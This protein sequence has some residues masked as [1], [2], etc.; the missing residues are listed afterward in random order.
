VRVYSGEDD[1]DYMKRAGKNEAN[2][3]YSINS[4]NERIANSGIRHPGVG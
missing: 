4:T 2:M 3:K 1:L